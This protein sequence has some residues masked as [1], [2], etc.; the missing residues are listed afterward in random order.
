MAEDPYK[1]DGVSA[2][3]ARGLVFLRR[4]VTVLTVVMIAGV[5]AI[6]ALLVIRLGDGPTTIAVPA[7]IAL[8]EGTRAIAV[9][10][11]ATNILVVTET[12][13]LLIFD[14]SGTELLGAVQL[15]DFI[16]TTD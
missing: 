16:E 5:L 12:E 14:A 9:T 7:Q 1:A 6:V 3:E 10:Q 2:E 13:N 15:G 4:L 11:T 8:P